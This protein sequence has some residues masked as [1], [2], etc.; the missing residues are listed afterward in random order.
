MTEKEKQIQK[1]AKVFCTNKYNS[2]DDSCLS[3]RICREYRHADALYKAGYRAPSEGNGVWVVER[4]NGDEI[5]TVP[6]TENQHGELFCSEC[7]DSALLDGV[8]DCVPSNY[9][10]NCGAKM[11]NATERSKQ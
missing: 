5:I 2:C 6:Y 4:Y 1:M 9:C 10:P 3:K 8:E 7:G 11:R